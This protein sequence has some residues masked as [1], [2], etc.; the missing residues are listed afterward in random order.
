[1]L[2]SAPA[3]EGG[4]SAKRL[5]TFVAD[6]WEQGKL[7]YRSLPW[8]HIDDPYGVLVSEVMLQQTQVARV[9]KHW[10]AWMRLFPTVDALAAA[11]TATVLEQWQGLGYNRRALALKRACE[12]CASEYGGAL[13]REEKDLLALPGV[14][15]ATCAGVRAF[16]YG[17]PSVY[18]ET[19][20]RTVFIHELF[21]GC[22]SVSD[23]ELR[24][25]VA[26]TCPQDQVRDWY[27]A[28]L[29]WGAHL[30]QTTVN[31]SRRSAH[32]VRQSA[33]E[34]S[35]RQKR[36]GALRYV[37]AHP[38]ARLADIALCLDEAER[39]AG[40]GGVDEGLVAGIVADLVAEGFFREE[41]GVYLP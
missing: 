28:L 27:Y 4:L 37:L 36:A 6:V 21:P 11:D 7:H 40:R 25:L 13:P 22:D 19:N 10:D 18:V 35:R 31:P 5:E 24:P 23:K 9:L 29:D 30:K 8:R 12:A 15:P 39:A 34:G 16:A 17:E 41:G 32:Y 14:G 26:Q 3:E 2:S 20:V 33:F 38:G 1:M